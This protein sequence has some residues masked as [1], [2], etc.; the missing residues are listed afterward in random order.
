MFS[1]VIRK[2]S[3]NRNKNSLNTMQ[4]FI[5][6]STCKNDQIVPHSPPKKNPTN[7]LIILYIIYENVKCLSTV[8]ILIT[9]RYLKFIVIFSFKIFKIYYN[10]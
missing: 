8:T 7:T 3:E 2:K 6:I 4:H 10:Y 1:S 5:I 9:K